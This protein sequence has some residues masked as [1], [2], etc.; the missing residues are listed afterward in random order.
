MPIKN[1]QPLPFKVKDI[2]LAEWGRKEMPSL[3]A[4]RKE[5]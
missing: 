5:Y 1:G 3:M 2:A 4:L